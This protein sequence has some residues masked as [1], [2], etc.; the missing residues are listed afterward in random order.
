MPQKF[1]ANYEHA[2]WRA[3]P[4]LAAQY[5]MTKATVERFVSPLLSRARHIVEVGPGPGTWTKLMLESNAEASYVLVD[6]SHEMLAQARA[7]LAGC[8]NVTY[9][10]SDLMSYLPAASFDLFFS[11]RAI[12][13]MPEKAKVCEKIF[14]LLCP[15]GYGIIITKM[16]KPFFN[17]L[18]GHSI[19]ALHTGQIEPYAL[20]KLLREHG[21]IVEKVS[22][23]TATVPGFHSSLLNRVAFTLLKHFSLRSPFNIFSESYL[24]LFKKPL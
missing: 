5:A 20:V 17:R 23:A 2:R 1:G 15:G 14:S 6:I 3:S 21:L 18:R 13:Y 12:E 7:I 10:E 19:A 4:L 9:I 22:I 8:A 16:P 11:S 24:I